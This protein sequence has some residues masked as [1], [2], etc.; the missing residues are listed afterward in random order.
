LI[1]IVEFLLGFVRSETILKIV[2]VSM[3]L[4]IGTYELPT[5]KTASDDQCV[6]FI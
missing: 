3:R 5:A 4:L 2:I 6:L 1:F